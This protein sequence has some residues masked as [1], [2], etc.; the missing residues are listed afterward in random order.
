[1]A[2][3]ARTVVP[4]VAHPVTPRGNRRQP[5]FFG[6]SD[7]LAYR[8]LVGTACAENR[9]RCLMPSHADGLCAALGE[10]YRRYS[11]RINL[12]HDWTGYLA[13]PL[14]QLSDG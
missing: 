12:A 11:C 5:V 8:D 10:P 4:D 6:E 13:G 14:R 7:Y 9:A 2:R 3:P 1:M